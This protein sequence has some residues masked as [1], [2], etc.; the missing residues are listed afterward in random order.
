MRLNG[1]SV[2]VSGRLMRSYGQSIRSQWVSKDGSGVSESVNI[3]SVGSQAQWTVSG[4]PVVVSVVSLGVKRQSVGSEWVS[5]L[6][7]W[8]LSVNGQSMETHCVS[9]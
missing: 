1:A 6:R 4:I 9:M 3:T 5:A 7:Q 2:G 8:G